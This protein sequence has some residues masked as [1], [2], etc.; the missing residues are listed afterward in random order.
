MK[1]PVVA[2]PQ[3]NTSEYMPLVYVTGVSTVGSIFWALGGAFGPVGIMLCGFGGLL[4]TIT[5]TLNALG[6]PTKRAEL[7]GVVVAWAVINYVLFGT[8]V[9]ARNQVGVLGI[10]MVAY[11]L[12]TF[13][14]LLV[15]EHLLTDE[16]IPSSKTSKI[17]AAQVAVQSLAAF[18]MFVVVVMRG[19]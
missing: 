9:V 7:M 4:I 3:Q 14:A 6:N 11:M 16:W 1:P 17:L 5:G 12:T 15:R 10:V 18:V 19:R 2:A 8:A 13:A